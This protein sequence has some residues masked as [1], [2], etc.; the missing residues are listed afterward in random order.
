MTFCDRCDIVSHCRVPRD[1]ALMA[2]VLDRLEHEN[3]NVVLCA[4][5]HRYVDAE[6]CLVRDGHVDL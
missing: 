4:H 3:R 6:S 2:K 5:L 1:R